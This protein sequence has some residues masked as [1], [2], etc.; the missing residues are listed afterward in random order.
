MYGGRVSGYGSQDRGLLMRHILD[1]RG[2]VMHAYFSGAPE[3]TVVN[4]EGKQVPTAAHAIKRFIEIYLRKILEKV[5]PINIIG[6]MEGGNNRR[7][8][9]F[10]EY[11]NKPSQSDGDPIM[12]EQIDAALTAAQKLLLGLGA[13]LVKTPTCEADDTIAWLC[14]GLQGDKHVYT[15]DQDLLQLYEYPGVTVQVKHEISKYF[16]GMD[17]GDAD[18]PAPI[19]MIRLYKSIVGDPSDNYA[20]VAGMGEAAWLRLVDTYGYDG[21]L[22]IGQCVDRMRYEDIESSLEA[23]PDR[24][25]QKLLTNKDQW[26]QSYV[27]AGLH[28]EWCES[29]WQDK[30]VRPQWGKRVPTVERLTAVLEPLGLEPMVAEFKFLCVQ[31]WGVDKKRWNQGNS[32]RMMQ[33]LQLSPMVAF[34]YESYDTLKH[35]PYRVARPGFVDVLNQEIVSCSFG[36][37]SNMQFAAYFS[38]N[39]RDTANLDLSVMKFLLEQLKDQTLIAQN[40]PFEM[41]LTK[42]NLGITMGQVLDTRVMSS[43]VNENFPDGLKDLSQ[44]YLN[45]QQTRYDEVVPKDGDMR[46][47]SMLEGLDYGC[48]DSICTAHLYVLFKAIM[49]CEGTWAFY[50][51]NEP[52]FDRVMMKSFIAGIPIDYAKL[53]ELQHE[54]EVLRESTQLEMRTLLKEHCSS[55]N[56]AGFD[57]LW[58]EIREYERGLFKLKHPEA[59]DEDFLEHVRP[60]KLE[61]YDKCAF[62]ELGPPD[63]VNNA[64]MIA[65]L[66]GLPTLRGKSK[67]WVEKY[68]QGIRDQALQ[69]GVALTDEQAVFLEAFEIGAGRDYDDMCK[70]VVSENKSVWVG[71]ELNI[72][73]P[74]QMAELFYGKMGLPILIRNI[75]KTGEGKR[76]L[77]ELEQAPSTAVVAIETWLAE[78]NDEDDWRFKVLKHILTLRGISTRFKLYYKTYPLLQSPTTGNLHPSIKNCGTVTRR[79]SGSAP[80]ILQIT[81]KDQ[82]KLR[83]IILPMADDGKT[84]PQC[85]VSIDFVQQELMILAAESN[86]AKLRSCYQ[87]A[88][89]MDVHS[90]TGTSLYNEIMR[91]AGKP[92]VTYA[93]FNA[94]VEAKEKDAWK[95]RKKIAKE[96][97]FLMAYRGS[98]AG[99]ARKAIVPKAMAEAFYDGFYNT[100]PGV[101]PYQ[102]QVIRQAKKTGFITTCFGNRKHCDGLFDRNKRIASS[103]E[104]QVVNMPIQ[105]GAADV[106]KTVMRQ[107]EK[108]G[109]LEQT[110]ATIYAP[111]YDELVASVPIVNVF[112]Y[113]DRMATIMELELPGRNLRLET[114][115][116]IG[117]NWGAQVEV[118]TRPTKQTIQEALEKIYGK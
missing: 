84:G 43:Y 93:Q 91:R 73:S 5:A 100:Y 35:A 36:F 3:D 33:H 65:K 9:I 101:G 83:S 49:E 66:I 12:A 51:E 99:L 88:N 15:V 85:V 77:W 53:S 78:I 52:A 13:M 117:K 69:N 56:E 104:R 103:W 71:D 68:C 97:N 116:S 59:S 113:C 102:E 45:Y 95:I 70:R 50:E 16:K 79:P 47:I 110:G 20:G 30:I 2:L 108:S 18:N 25:L 92:P 118:G 115:V 72:D 39:H 90:L 48:D 60:R 28:P 24:Q 62:V 7:R 54:D 55:I 76:T 1:L 81:K 22:Q 58:P 112:E 31:K 8:A 21:M 27:L 96:T 107:T 75:D 80:N 57:T 63:H 34:D 41:T 40:A 19:Q 67:A 86:D 109:L 89:R 37:G 87:G 11:K 82:G 42:N 111:V 26:R 94:L 29:S 46:D 61:L 105:G 4:K 17:F 14:K 44:R 6:V 98:A 64:S 74:K 38:F 32:L 114:S 10:P 23:Q 106:L